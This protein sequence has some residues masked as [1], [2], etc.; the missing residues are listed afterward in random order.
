MRL[1]HKLG[2]VGI[3]ALSLLG[4]MGL[5]APS[6]GADTA[7]HYMTLSGST[8]VKDDEVIARRDKYCNHDLTGFDSA[9]VP[10][11][12]SAKVDDTNNTCGGEVRAEVHITG[13]L[14]DAGRWCVSGVVELYEGTRADNHDLDG[15]KALSQKCTDAGGTIEWDGRVNNT[16]EGGDWAD[17][18]VDV[19]A[20]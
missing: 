12:T 1:R 3:S 13:T 20:G 10:R 6:A 7:V 19:F 5:D 11:D 4:T 16:N 14:N 8:R 18:H 15:T 17:Y 2:I 9:Q